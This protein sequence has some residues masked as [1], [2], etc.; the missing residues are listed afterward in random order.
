MYLLYALATCTYVCTAY[1]YCVT[2][3]LF[4][5]CTVVRT[6]LYCY[7]V[8][9]IILQARTM[10]STDLA[11]MLLATAQ[12]A[13]YTLHPILFIIALGYIIGIDIS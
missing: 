6:A 9:D 1:L 12:G 10:L 7:L 5:L 4:V 2:R 13:I 8:S 3:K 11:I